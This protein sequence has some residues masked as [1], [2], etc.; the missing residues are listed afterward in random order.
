MIIESTDIPV[1]SPALAAPKTQ[2]TDGGRHHHHEVRPG[3]DLW[4]LAERYYGDGRDWRKIAAANPT[5]LTGGPDRLQVGWRLRI[6]DLDDGPAR[7]GGRLVTVRRGDTLSA[8][9]ERE[10]GAAAR[11][12]DIF[13]ATELS[14]VTQINS[15][16]ECA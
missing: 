1:D 14:S 11:W 4:S 16:W 10:L 2:R 13:H 15:P 9:A 5:V 6:P 12:T 8:I 3:D 7:D